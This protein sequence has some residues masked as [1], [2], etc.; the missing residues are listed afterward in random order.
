MSARNNTIVFKNRLP[1]NRDFKRNYPK[2]C[3]IIRI[4]ETLRCSCGRFAGDSNIT[5]SNGRFSD[6]WRRG[7]LT[8]ENCN[9]KLEGAV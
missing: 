6:A 2:V 8:C 7:A 3:P 5:G 1:A 4:A 9:R